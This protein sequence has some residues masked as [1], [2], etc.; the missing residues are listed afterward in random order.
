[1]DNT[2]ANKLTTI[3]NF[4]DGKIIVQKQCMAS[5]ILETY[6]YFIRYKT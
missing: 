6:T 1:M 2:E 5:L 3:P 4:G